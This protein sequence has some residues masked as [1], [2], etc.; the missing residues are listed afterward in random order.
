M[1]IVVG[2]MFLVIIGSLA[3]AF[4]YMMKDRSQSNRTAKALTVRISVSV[5]L[6]LMIL[7]AH[8]M[9]WIESTGIR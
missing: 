7:F 5:T 4:L 9:G 6:F 3:S 2:L 8:Y 1:K